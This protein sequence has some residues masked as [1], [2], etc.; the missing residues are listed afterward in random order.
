MQPAVYAV[1]E[2]S[3][4][5]ELFPYAFDLLPVPWGFNGHLMVLLYT[6]DILYTASNPFL[7]P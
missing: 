2:H 4:L 3:V 5:E 7:M 6:L 1:A